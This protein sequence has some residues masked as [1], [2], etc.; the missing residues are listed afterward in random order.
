MN[1][2]SIEIDHN[3]I[4]L[5]IRILQAYMRDVPEDTRTNPIPNPSARPPNSDIEL[6]IKKLGLCWGQGG[7]NEKLFKMYLI[8]TEEYTQEALQ[9][10][11]D[12]WE[13]Q[14]EEN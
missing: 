10:Y 2:N 13:V 12:A 4:T 7:M 9:R 6:V 14:D 3:T 8:P 11:V 1:S 5:I